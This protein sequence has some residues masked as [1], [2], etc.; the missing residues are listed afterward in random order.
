MTCYGTGTYL[1]MYGTVPVCWWIHG[2]HICM[3]VEHRERPFFPAL[4]RFMTSGPVVPMVWQGNNVVAI[5]RYRTYRTVENSETR[6]RYLPKTKIKLKLTDP[7]LDPTVPLC[8]K[9]KLLWNIGTGTFFYHLLFT[10]K[11][12]GLHFTV[13]VPGTYQ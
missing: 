13:L 3:C 6:V 2:V 12:I 10:N 11:C 8:L 4:I 1:F 9:F 7:F 5:S